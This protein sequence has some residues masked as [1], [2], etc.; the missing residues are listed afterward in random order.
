MNELFITQVPELLTAML[1]GS[2]SGSLGFSGSDATALFAS[3]LGS[4]FFGA[5]LKAVGERERIRRKL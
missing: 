4:T 3:F 2:K 5:M 1:F